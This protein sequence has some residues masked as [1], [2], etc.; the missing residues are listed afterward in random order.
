MDKRKI[1]KELRN[2]SKVS[3]EH[4]DMYIILER[5]NIKWKI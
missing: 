5:E 1:I 3:E 4:H 2:I